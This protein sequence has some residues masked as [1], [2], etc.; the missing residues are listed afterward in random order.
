MLSSLHQ[1][2]R[3]DVDQKEGGGDAC[4][5]TGRNLPADQAGVAAIE[6]ALLAALIAIAMLGGLTRLGGETTRIWDS[7]ST[8]VTSA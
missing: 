4:R 1:P 3:V 6:Y 5:T 7:I 2:D 8:D